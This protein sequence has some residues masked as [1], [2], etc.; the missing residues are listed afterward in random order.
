MGFTAI[1]GASD[2]PLHYGNFILHQELVTSP[3]GSHVWDAVANC[4]GLLLDTTHKNAILPPLK[5]LF[6]VLNYSFKANNSYPVLCFI[7]EAIL[8]FP[9]AL[10]E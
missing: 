7:S 1:A 9:S 5:R 8:Q 6:K 10:P 3:Q 2:F 4:H